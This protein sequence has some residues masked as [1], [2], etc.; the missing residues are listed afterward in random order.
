VHATAAIGEITIPGI[1]RRYC[2]C[3]LV[4]AC[5][6]SLPATTCGWT[7]QKLARLRQAMRDHG[8]LSIAA[9]AVDET[10]HRAN[11]AL[12]A[13]LGRNPHQ[14]LAA[15]EARAARQREEADK[16]R[17]AAPSPALLQALAELNGVRARP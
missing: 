10:Q 3:D 5:R 9:A 15:M 4:R 16:A 7:V 11:I 12:E 17:D 14:A 8:S 6:C 13:L 2:S 1:V